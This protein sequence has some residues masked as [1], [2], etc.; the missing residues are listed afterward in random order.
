MSWP[1]HSEK[2][3]FTAVGERR[4]VGIFGAQL[5]QSNRVSPADVRTVRVNSAVSREG[6][7]ESKK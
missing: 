5:R 4:Y 6:N 3:L 1:K 7:R 2:V